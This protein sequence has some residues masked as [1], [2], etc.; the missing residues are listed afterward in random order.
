RKSVEKQVEKKYNKD[1]VAFITGINDERKVLDFMEFCKFSD[2]FILQSNDYQIYL[3]IN[4][5][6]KEFCKLNKANSLG[7]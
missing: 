6:Y 3:A 7:S 2:D 4:N 1:I 5:C